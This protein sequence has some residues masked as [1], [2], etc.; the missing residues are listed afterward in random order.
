[1]SDG[2]IVIDTGIDT[3]GITK[4]V[5]KVTKKVADDLGKT[6]TNT[7]KK[8][9][10]A[11]NNIGKAANKVDFSKVTKQMDTISRSIENTNSKI[12]IQKTKLA[13]LKTSFENAT[14]PKGKN[15]IQEQMLNTEATI[16]NLESK[17]G[18]LGTRL[19]SLNSKSAKSAANGLDGE[20]RSASV[21]ITKSLDNIEEKAKETGNSIRKN[22]GSLSIGEGI[23]KVGNNISSV[24]DKL[25]MGV[26]LPLVGVG[27]AAAKVGM[28]FDSAMSRVKAISGATG[29]DFTDLKNQA[30]DLGASTAFSAKEAASGMENLASAGFTTKEI[31]VAMPGMLDLAA[32]SGEDLASSADIAASTL[33]GFGLAADQAGHVAD[34]LAKNAGATNAAVADTGEAMKY[35]A[36]IAKTMGWSL[37]EVTAAIGEMADQGIKGSQSG[38]T[39]RSAV[40]SLVKPSKEAAEA[41]ATMGFKAFDSQGKMKPLNQLVS[42]LQKSTKGM[43]DEQKQNNI[44]TIFGQES[45]SGMLAL[46]SDGPDKLNALTESYKSSDGAAKEMAKTMQDNA[47]SS[48]E[49]MVGS[50]ETAAIKVEEVFAP[51]ITELA[52]DIQG[53]ANEFAEL[54]PEQ[55][56]FYT[57]LLMGV[58]AAGPLLKLVG[59]LTNGVGGLIKVS[60]KLGGLF[61]LGAETTATSGGMTGLLGG[62]SALTPAI[63]PVVGAFAGLGVVIAA[64]NTSQDQMKDKLTTTTDGMSDWEKAINGMTGYTFKS[65]KEL[66]ALGIEYKDFGDNISDNFKTKVIEST[67]TLHKFEL[68]LK[69]INLDGIISDSESTDFNNQI[70]KMVG[71]SISTIESKKTESQEALKKLFMLDDDTIDATEQATI[72]AVSKG[73]DAQINS[74]N[75]LKTEILAIKQKAVDEKRALNEQEIKD[76]Q[77]KTNKIKEIELA[78]IGGNEEEQAYSKNEFG[79]R[80]STV[81][82]EDASKI[83]Q[84]KKKA[85]DEENIQIQAGY[86]TQLDMLKIQLDK[87]DEA[88]KS[89][90]KS[91]IDKFT[92]LKDDKT[93]LHNKEYDEYLKI[94]Q[95]KNPQALALIDIYN[96]EELTKADVVSQQKLVGM[97]NTF[98]GLNSITESG[99]YQ[100][101]NTQTKLMED[102]TLTYDKATGK[103]TGAYAETTAQVGGYTDTMAKDTKKLGQAHAD[104][105]ATCNI[106]LEGLGGATVDASGKITGANLQTVGSLE[107]VTTATDGTVTGILNV[108]DTPITIETNAD[109]TIKNMDDVIRKI[110][111][112]PKSKLITFDFKATGFGEITNKLSNIAIQA[113]NAGISA[114]A[115]IHNN[116]T[117]TNGGDEGL[118]YVNEHGWE[119]SSGSEQVAMLGSGSQIT[120]HM[121]SVNEMNQE[122]SEQIGNTLTPIMKVL[123]NVLGQVA[124]NTGAIKNYTKETAS[125]I[126]DSMNSNTGTFAT[127]QSELDNAN[128]A[129]DN[130]SNLSIEDN[131]AYIDAKAEVD[132][133]SDMTSDS[134]KALGEEQLKIQKD[135]ADKS[136]DLAKKAAELDIIIAKQNAD[137]RV[138]IAEANKNKLIKMA[139]AVTTAL[140]T[141]LEK[142]KATAEKAINDE[143]DAMETTYNKK[144]AKIEANLKADTSDIDDKIAELEQQSTDTSREDTRTES[145]N[146]IN[147]LKT[148]M[149]NAASIADKQ[150]LELQIKDA[151]KAMSEQENTWNIED[152]KAKLEEEK[153]LLAEK[154]AAKKESLQAEYEESKASKEKELKTTDEYYDKLLETDSLNAQTRYT[155]LTTSSDELVALLN[156]YSPNWQNAGQSLGDSLLTGLNTS[157]QSVQDAV[158]DMVALRGSTSSNNSLS[159]Y[160]SGTSYNKSAGLYKV[161]ENKWETSSSGSVAYVSK[162]AAINNHMQSVADM[163]AEISRQVASMM[164]SIQA[165]QS[166]M[167]VQLLGNIA[168]STNNSVTHNDNGL[169]FQIENLNNYSSSDTEQL[170]NEAE[171]YRQ[172]QKKA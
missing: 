165:E 5:E 148:K 105:S 131:Q 6:T 75:E 70:S 172:R 21:S 22:M 112:I 129:K 116:Y 107:D 151:N 90:I 168:S 156:S 55:Q 171:T 50:L 130:A 80:V 118:S 160:A 65:K 64:I 16:I 68:F 38:T 82:P 157:K 142:E 153:T 7:M 54:S 87:A 170:M 89:A 102:V 92:K 88:D 56:M 10:T 57:K 136:L 121:T 137:D 31:M 14:T 52:N 39:L 125:N 13:T 95:E 26:T 99:T 162:G 19:S 42:D 51:T 169:I 150:A 30:I 35:I 47:K 141:Q 11:V 60:S 101:K 93:N 63:I 98:T 144:V 18:T 97:K 46:I 3:I 33:R 27:V 15:K 1:M 114:K 132:R 158:N 167:K 49:Q 145:S 12:E 9:E 66:Q 29:E 128:Y 78:A 140:K 163:K 85:I 122:I 161:D 37:E 83:L 106:A 139:E 62:L 100:L 86:D 133:I 2:K 8:V 59:G 43:T 61:G 24:G 143:L 103:I 108:N 113:A 84:D 124:N 69:T 23:I 147:M 58:A 155:M 123:T 104:M 154:A 79:A 119:I 28:D 81:S 117:G 53:L 73:F 17:L 126:I 34:V 32:S 135:S 96:G 41:M 36:P 134:K 71:A 109:G 120:P 94:L 67:D 152:E 74:E 40:T 166:Q 77:N 164:S 115:N 45:M 25:T 149:A 48:I 91:T 146:N 20:F 111:D 127:V 4:D 110:A 76:V 44:A 72:D 159:G 138:K